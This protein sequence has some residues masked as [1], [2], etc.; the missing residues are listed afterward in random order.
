LLIDAG[1]DFRMQA[2]TNQ[3]SYVDAV[4]LT[5]H[6]YDHIAGIDD[7]RPLTERHGTMRI[8]GRPDTLAQVR[9]VFSYAFHED[10]L[11]SSRPS[12]ELVPIAGQFQLGEV[13]IQP[14]EVMHGIHAINGYRIGNLAY[15]TDASAISPHSLDMLQGVKVL[16]INALRYI[17]H[18]T[19]FSL[20]QALEVI[21]TVRPE[22]AYL[23]HLTHVFDH[24]TVQAELPANVL[25]A[26]DGLQVE[27]EEPTACA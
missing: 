9:E 21:A 3:L 19:H 4:L 13:M 23:V 14:I 18:P 6:H 15:I 12:L 17:P 24:A 11:G 8:Y 7:L 16:V 2:L 10:A 25:L 1:I 5:H 27:L 22:R 26:Y 20:E